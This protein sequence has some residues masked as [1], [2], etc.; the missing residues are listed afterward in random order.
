[1]KLVVELINGDNYL[2]CDPIKHNMDETGLLVMDNTNKMFLFPL[3][4]ILVAI[5]EEADDE[6]TKETDVQSKEVN[7]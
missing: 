5:L 4:S 7:E 1:M 3:Q 6:T 2:F